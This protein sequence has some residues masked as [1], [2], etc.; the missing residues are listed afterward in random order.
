MKI[1]IDEQKILT[2]IL[3]RDESLHSA[4]KRKV[5]ER[6][7]DSL[8]KEIEDKYISKS[9]GGKEEISKNVLEDLQEHQTKLVVKI[10]KDFYESYRYKKADVQI[11]KKLKDFIGENDS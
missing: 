10:L 9:W 1:E 7:V 8:T 11:L 4:I 6:L 3:E 5:E 2:E